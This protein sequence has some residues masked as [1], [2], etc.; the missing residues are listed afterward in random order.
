[1]IRFKN[2]KNLSKIFILDNDQYLNLID[3]K[4]KR[5]NKKSFLMWAILILIIAITWMSQEVI[6]FLIKV[7]KPEIFLN[8]YML[9]VQFLLIIQSIMICTNIFY[10]SKDIEQ[11]LFLPIRPI[12]ILISKINTL[13]FIL[14]NTEMIFGTIPFIIYGIYTGMGYLFNITLV[15]V[16]LIFPVFSA[17]FISMFMIFLMN[18]L[19]FIKNKDLMQILVAFI[20]IGFVIAMAFLGIKNIFSYR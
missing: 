5:I 7:G 15:I 20:L 3:K 2:V 12:E 18:I 11:I 4:N 6:K 1:M 10:F 17:I 13:I 14:Y 19:K 16:L 9:F 8:A